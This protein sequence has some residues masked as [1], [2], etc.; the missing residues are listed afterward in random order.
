MPA[1]DGSRHVRSPLT[2]EEW[3]EVEALYQALWAAWKALKNAIDG[4]VRARPMNEIWSLSPRLS[5]L[6]VRLE[7]EAVRQLGGEAAPWFHNEPRPPELA[8]QRRQ[9]RP[10]PDPRRAA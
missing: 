6:G 3:Q 7:S 9:A 4:N 1:R 5:R 10:E 8:R 2:A